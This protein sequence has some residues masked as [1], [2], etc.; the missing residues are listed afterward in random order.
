MFQRQFNGAR[1]REGRIYRGLTITDL[2]N[3]LVVSKQMISKYENNKA[4]PNLDSLLHITNILKFPREYFYET[5]V[6]VKTGS[7]YF[8]SLLTTGK[9]EREMQYDR[10]KYLTIIRALLEEYVD[11]PELDVPDFSERDIESVEEIAHQVRMAW[12]LSDKPIKD[13][14]Y[15]LETKGFVVSSLKLDNKMIDAFGS[16][17]EIQG[18]LYYSIVLGNDKR[19][20]YR[21]QFDVAHELGHKVLHDPYLNIEDLSKEEFKQIEQE[22]NDFAAAFLLPKESFLRDVSIHPSDLNYYKLLK[23][24]WCV[25]IG[26]MVMR[27]YKLGAINE[28]TYQYMQRSLSQKGWRTK[29]PL[30]DLKDL[31][32]PVSMK[33]AIELLIENDYIS[34][35]G[36]MQKLSQHYGLSLLREEV[37]ELLGLEEGY[38]RTEIAYTGNIVSIKDKLESRSKDKTS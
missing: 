14:I 38:L 20:F 25:S 5:S 31:K 19:S 10:V 18:K 15:L 24:K 26:A 11:F 23:K 21:R 3:E 2:A 1:L 7:T 37:E 28:G 9:K 33:Q 8:R 36:F 17:H 35:E 6:E 34:G 12:S 32:D 29:E 13:I 22:A 4:I 30:D 16:Q 27:A